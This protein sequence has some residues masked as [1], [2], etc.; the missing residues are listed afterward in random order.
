[1]FYECKNENCSCSQS[2]SANDFTSK[3]NQF[4]ISTFVCLNEGRE[5]RVKK[6][7]NFFTYFFNRYLLSYVT[8]LFLVFGI[9]TLVCLE[10]REGR[11]EGEKGW[12]FFNS[13]FQL[14]SSFKCHLFFW[15][16]EF[17][18]LFVQREKRERGVKRVEAPLSTVASLPLSLKCQN[19]MSKID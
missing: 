1:M 7:W 6:S 19:L 16:L 2:W 12:S 10:W 11:E 17:Q 13:F 14:I 18:L 3:N 5:R 8:S 9:S 4:G 15:H